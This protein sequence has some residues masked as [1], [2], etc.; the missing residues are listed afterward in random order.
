MQDVSF[1]DDP[2]HNKIQS[3]STYC[4]G[5]WLLLQFHPK[6]IT[7]LIFLV[8]FLFFVFVLQENP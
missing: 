4:N 1:I 6:Y 2:K 5:S 7:V 8:C 3:G